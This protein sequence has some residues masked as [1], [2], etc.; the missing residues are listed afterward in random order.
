MFLLIH[1]NGVGECPAAT[2]WLLLPLAPPLTDAGKGRE[3]QR[4]F[5]THIVGFGLIGGTNQFTI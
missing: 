4:D 2:G 5:A 1:P 3:G